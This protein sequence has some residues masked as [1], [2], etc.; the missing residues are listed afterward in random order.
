MAYKGKY[1]PK[2]PSKYEGDPGKVTYR[3]LWERNAFRWCDDNSKIR[4]WSSEEVIIPY[5]C[6]TDNK[7]HRYFMDLKITFENGSTYLIEIKPKKETVPPNS[8][9]KKTQ[10]YL[11]E[12]LT[13]TKNMSKWEAASV[14]AT[15]RGWTFEVWHEDTLESLGIKTLKRTIKPLRR[16]KKNK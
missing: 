8:G 3:S 2:N 6:K 5:R 13:Y 15:Q 14:Y 1:R 10:R 16:K 11:T 7:I 9:R 12:V 4:S